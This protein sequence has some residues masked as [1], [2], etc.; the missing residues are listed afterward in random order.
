MFETMYWL[1]NK[2]LSIQKH[3]Q[4][5]FLYVRKYFLS[6]SNAASII[7][8]AAGVANGVYTGA[9]PGSPGKTNG[10][11]LRRAYMAGVMVRPDQPWMK[12]WGRLSCFRAFTMCWRSARSLAKSGWGATGGELQRNPATLLK[13]TMLSIS[14]DNA[15][16]Q[17][18]KEL[19]S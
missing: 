17:G 11:C 7:L 14:M 19:T 4:L 8:I 16:A 12:L 2:S 3:S 9:G 6:C 10:L 15:W 5:M 18:G 1:G 13:V